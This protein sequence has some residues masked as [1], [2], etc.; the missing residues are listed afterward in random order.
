[1][2]VTVPLDVMNTPF[3]NTS[4]LNVTGTD[5]TITCKSAQH[6]STTSPWIHVGSKRQFTLPLELE[7]ALEVAIEE[8]G[9]ALVLE[10]EE[11]A[12]DSLK[13]E[14]TLELEELVFARKLELCDW[15]NDGVGE[16]KSVGE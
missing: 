16:D 1:L 10:L 14:V 11:L 7:E 5:T 3:K 12:F 13:L 15:D 4:P 6:T 2:N 9:L 8:L